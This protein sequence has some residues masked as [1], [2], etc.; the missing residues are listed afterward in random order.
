MR[1]H[2]GKHVLAKLVFRLE[3]V[4]ETGLANPNRIRDLLHRGPVV[5]EL[6]KQPG[7]LGQNL[8]AHF[9]RPYQLVAKCLPNGREKA[10]RSPV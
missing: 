7:R 2:L 8:S 1:K 6:G 5:P 4:E 3:V 9:H 10:S